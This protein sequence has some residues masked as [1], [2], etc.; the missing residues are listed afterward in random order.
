[1]KRA[2]CMSKLEILKFI[3]HALSRPAE[4]MQKNSLQMALVDEIYHCFEETRKFIVGKFFTGTQRLQF[5][6]E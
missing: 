2:A 4:L 5:C 1:M 6:S 3:F